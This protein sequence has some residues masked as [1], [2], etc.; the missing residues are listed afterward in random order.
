MFS[1]LRKF[2][3]F[4][5]FKR[6][7]MIS[8][9]VA[10]AYGISQLNQKP[11]S[12]SLNSLQQH[13]QTLIM[14]P[15]GMLLPLDQ[16]RTIAA[17]NKH[18]QDAHGS[19]LDLRSIMPWF[20]SIEQRFAVGDMSVTNFTQA[21]KQQLKMD[22]PDEV[23][24]DSWNAMLGNPDPQ[25]ITQQLS[26]AQE[27]FQQSPVEIIPYA[28]T[29]PLHYDFLTKR[30][31]HVHWESSFLWRLPKELLPTAIVQAKKQQGQIDG[32]CLI[33]PPYEN[34]PANTTQARDSA[35]AEES[36]KRLSAY[37][38]AKSISLAIIRNGNLVEACK[39]CNREL[40]NFAA[41]A[42]AATQRKSW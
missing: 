16:R 12:R 41:K 28:H 37:C 32:V 18:Y 25:L 19:T 42:Q 3:M 21:L 30:L 14:C 38:E 31:P 29:N 39:L 15:F 5:P 1:L 6:L 35:K 36:A 34:T 22:V 13:H 8:S 4:S 23:I 11:S 17:F 27:V 20:L 10:A 40:A 24:H 9:L 2:G 7:S 33:L 26:Q